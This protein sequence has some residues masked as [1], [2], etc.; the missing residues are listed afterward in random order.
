[1]EF[2]ADYPVASPDLDVPTLRRLADSLPDD[3]RPGPL[4]QGL[5]VFL[6]T[7]DALDTL[8]DR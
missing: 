6:V 1:M 7:G 5:R 3:D 2:L 4:V 8:L